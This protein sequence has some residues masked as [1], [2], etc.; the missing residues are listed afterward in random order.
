MDKIK[1]DKVTNWIKK[2]KGPYVLSAKLDGI[3]IIY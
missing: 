3:C 1:P 2:F